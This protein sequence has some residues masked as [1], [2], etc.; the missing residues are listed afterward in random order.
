VP[1]IDT[2]PPSVFTAFAS[3]VDRLASE[4]AGQEDLGSLHAVLGSALSRAAKLLPARDSGDANARMRADAAL[5]R[6]R[7][8]R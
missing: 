2:G 4:Q 3:S 7:E 5:A 6:L 8:P 1:T